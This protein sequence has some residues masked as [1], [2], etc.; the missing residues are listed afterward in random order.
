MYLGEWGGG[1]K[2]GGGEGGGGRGGGGGWGKW[3]GGWEGCGER[4]GGNAVSE[5]PKCPPQKKK[6]TKKHNSKQAK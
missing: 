2:R 6:M 5:S 4:G 3:R 1:G